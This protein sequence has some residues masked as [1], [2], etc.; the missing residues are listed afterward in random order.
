MWAAVKAERDG[1]G[2][3]GRKREKGV[4]AAKKVEKSNK[5]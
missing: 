5:R 3:K 1:G 2:R 4:K